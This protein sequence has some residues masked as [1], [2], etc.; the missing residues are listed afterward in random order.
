M[1]VI[2]QV[3]FLLEC[4]NFEKKKKKKKKTAIQQQA[5]FTPTG[6]QII[7]KARQNVDPGGVSVITAGQ[8]C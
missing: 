3:K 5:S 2:L 6:L 1:L 4:L 7:K 8:G